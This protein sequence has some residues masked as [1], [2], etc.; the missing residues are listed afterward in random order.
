MS[1][2]LRSGWQVEV[3][4]EHPD[5]GTDSILSTITWGQTQTSNWKTPS[6]TRPIPQEKKHRGY[7]RPPKLLETLSSQLHSPLIF[8]SL[9]PS[10][11][12][13]LINC[14]CDYSLR[15]RKPSLVHFSL[16]LGGSSSVCNWCLNRDPIHTLQAILKHF[17]LLK[18]DPLNCGLRA[19]EN[20]EWAE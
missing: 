19:N 13:P 3:H 10:I 4:P 12:L 1:K 7:Q 5:D 18:K 16:P 15:A 2:I 11:K 6:P 17:S 14:Q 8:F 20:K 9:I